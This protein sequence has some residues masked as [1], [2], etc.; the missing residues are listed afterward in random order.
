[1]GAPLL[2]LDGKSKKDKRGG[3]RRHHRRRCR[4]R[5]R[6]V[7]RMCRVCRM[8]RMCRVCCAPSWALAVRVPCRRATSSC[9]SP[10]ER[11]CGR[12]AAS[13][14]A[15]CQP[16]HPAHSPQPAAHPQ[17][18]ARS[19]QSPQAAAATRLPPVEPRGAWCLAR[20]RCCRASTS[21]PRASRV[22]LR[23]QLAP[24]CA[25]RAPLTW[26]STARVASGAIGW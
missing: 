21:Q 13:S 5:R 19:P 10:P 17:P 15:H 20:H 16:Q 9:S 1:M 8:R 6:R 23:R 24:S 26:N 18:T 7:C 12:H 11:S 22:S 3:V 14:T 2:M 25:L 4:G